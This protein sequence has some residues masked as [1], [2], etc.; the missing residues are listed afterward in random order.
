MNRHTHT[1]T[2]SITHTTTTIISAACI[3]NP[4]AWLSRLERTRSRLYFFSI[5]LACW[6]SF[7]IWRLY[8]HTP[9]PSLSHLH[10][11]DSRARGICRSLS[12]LCASLGRGFI[13]SVWNE[14]N[15]T[16]DSNDFFVIIFYAEFSRLHSTGPPLGYLTIQLIIF[17]SQMRRQLL[18]CPAC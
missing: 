11:L 10:L 17:R 1:H 7:Y 5:T 2:H 13:S 8:T 3:D 15:E 12:H 6:L 18:T 16:D 9:Y 4:T 14:T